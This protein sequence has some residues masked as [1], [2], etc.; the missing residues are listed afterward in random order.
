[1][2]RLRTAMLVLK[3]SFDRNPFTSS[4]RMFKRRL[5]SRRFD[6]LW[7]RIHDFRRMIRDGK[8]DTPGKFFSVSTARIQRMVKLDLGGGFQSGIR[9]VG[10]SG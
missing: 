4:R 1:M 2:W 5:R 6:E 8:H 10:N 9:G 3:K 7:S